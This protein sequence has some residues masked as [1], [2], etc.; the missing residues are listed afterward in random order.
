[1]PLVLQSSSCPAK[2]QPSSGD[3]MFLALFL[4]A[5]ERFNE[6]DNSFTD[7]PEERVLLL[8]SLKSVSLWECKY[9][10]SFLES[11]PSTPDEVM[12]YIQCMSDRE[13]GDT[14][15]KRY[16]ADMQKQ[17]I[18]YISDQKTATH[19]LEH[20][21][22]NQGSSDTLTSELLYYAMFQ[23]NIPIDVEEWHLSRLLALLRIFSAKNSQATKTNDPRS[24][25]AARSALNM[26]RRSRTNSKG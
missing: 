3:L 18:D 15:F 5:E 12:Y 8:H 19:L 7:F 11:P 4:P 22:N 13:L 17:V 21:N 2:S 26:A 20:S 10:R 24:S 1:M 23:N 25:A 14:F 9:K 6:H 16:D